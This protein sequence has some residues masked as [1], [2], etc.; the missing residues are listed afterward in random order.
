MVPTSDYPLRG[1]WLLSPEDLY[2]SYAARRSAAAPIHAALRSLNAG[3]R[4]TYDAAQVRIR[5]QGHAVAQL[6]EKGKRRAAA[7]CPLRTSRSKSWPYS[8]AAL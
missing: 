5:H 3:D 1:Y 6:S 8:T 7:C 4:V 2:L